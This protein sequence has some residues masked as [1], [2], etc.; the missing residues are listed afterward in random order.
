[1]IK[2]FRF[3][4]FFAALEGYIKLERLK[5]T[6]KLNHFALKAKLY[7]HALRRAFDS[8]QAFQLAP[9]MY[10]RVIIYS[11]RIFVLRKVRS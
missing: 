11:F 8:L 9:G 10:Y 5:G 4:H 3:L 1:V 6:T 7:A 2:Y